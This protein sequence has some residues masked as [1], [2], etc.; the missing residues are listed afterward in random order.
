LNF[1]ENDVDLILIF[2][3]LSFSLANESGNDGTWLTVF[4]FR[5]TADARILIDEFSRF[6]V[7][8]KYVV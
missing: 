1:N 5:T 7:I 8:E 3:P 4:G 6:G 2:S